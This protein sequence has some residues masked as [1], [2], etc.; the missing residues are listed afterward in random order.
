M[1]IREFERVERN[2]EQLRKALSATKDTYH[3]L[4]IKENVLHVSPCKEIDTLLNKLQL[5]EK[6]MLENTLQREGF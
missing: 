1:N 6:T 3:R 5:L 4:C 2:L